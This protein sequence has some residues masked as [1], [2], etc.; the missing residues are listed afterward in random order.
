[1]I[2]GGEIKKNSGCV[3]LYVL[4]NIWRW[5]VDFRKGFKKYEVIRGMK[6]KSG[7]GMGL[8]EVMCGERKGLFVGL[9]GGDG[10]GEGLYLEGKYE[11]VKEFGRKV[12]DVGKKEVEECCGYWLVG[13]EEKGGKKIIGWSLLGVFYE[14]REEGGV[15]EEGGMG[16]VRGGVEVEKKVYEQVKLW[17]ELKCDEMKKKKNRVM[18]GEKG[19]GDF[20]GLLGELKKGGGVGEKGK[21]YVM[22]GIKRKVKEM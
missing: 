8:Y 13:K 7:Y 1:M 5:L 17:F 12:M 15:E 4:D 16:K 19:I 11:K 20:M 18:E 9:E 10:V 22:G 6:F 3:K 21:G 14:K 2:S